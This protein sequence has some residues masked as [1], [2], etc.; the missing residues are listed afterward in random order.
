[1]ERK[2]DDYEIEMIKSLNL[3]QK[4]E[5]RVI[6]TWREVPLFPSSISNLFIGIFIASLSILMLNYFEFITISTQF[7][8]FVLG[9][10]WMFNMFLVMEIST[11]KS[12]LQM[13]EEDW[14]FTPHAMK[15]WRLGIGVHTKTVFFG[16]YGFF[17]SSVD[18]I[19]ALIF[20]LTVIICYFNFV[21]V[22]D[23]VEKYIQQLNIN[24]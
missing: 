10:S 4:A 21:F 1:M 19:L 2:L 20:L 18:S 6:N 5:T 24:Q 17:L 7:S 9:L 13:K 22:R 11:V 23:K 8:S 14:V 15:T 3:S 16:L 12:Y